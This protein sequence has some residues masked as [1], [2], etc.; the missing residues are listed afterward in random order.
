MTKILPIRKTT[1]HTSLT[2]QQ[3]TERIFEITGNKTNQYNE[4]LGTVQKDYFKISRNI[5]YRNSFLPVITG[6][7]KKGSTGTN[8]EIKAK[9]NTFVTTF[10]IIWMSI[11]GASC[12]GIIITAFNTPD[13]SEKI[14]SESTPTIIPFALLIIGGVI[15][16]APFAAEYN[17]ALNKLKEILE[18]KEP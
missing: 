13:L 17:I 6:N 11:I 12:V 1:L 10:M 4:F 9:P 14:S 7:I 2:P 8:I 15:F 16:N 3:V 5:N 18:A